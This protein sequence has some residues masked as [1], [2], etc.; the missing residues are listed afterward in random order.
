MKKSECFLC[1][2]EIKKDIC[3]VNIGKHDT[4]F[5]KYLH[6]HLNCFEN[7]MGCS[8]SEVKRYNDEVRPYFVFIYCK[9]KEETLQDFSLKSS[10]VIRVPLSIV[11]NDWIGEEILS[12]V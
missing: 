1:E 8:L 11:Q 9:P 7:E 5:N 3:C 12:L 2:E 4:P 6:F 10:T